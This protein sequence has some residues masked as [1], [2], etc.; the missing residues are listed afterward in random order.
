MI[1]LPIVKSESLHSD[2]PVKSPIKILS[3]VDT[4]VEIESAA[5]TAL[6]TKSA[7]ESLVSTDSKVVQSE[8]SKV[9]LATPLGVSMKERSKKGD[10]VP[11][12]IP[13][14]PSAA[15]PCEPA[16]VTI[17]KARHRRSSSV[18]NMTPRGPF[19]LMG[20][21]SPFGDS[22]SSPSGQSSSAKSKRMSRGYKEV[23]SRMDLPKPSWKAIVE[24]EMKGSKLKELLVA[25][26]PDEG[27]PNLAEYIQRKMENQN[28]DPESG[29]KE[30]D[31]NSMCS[32]DRC[33]LEHLKLSACL[34]LFLLCLAKDE[35]L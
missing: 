16:S 14:T 24:R 29:S 12:P 15:T 3:A 19:D 27:S 17:L 26:L 7:A 2:F 22:P 30:N 33:E 8:G 23:T 13:A 20:E 32:P 6:E 28:R 25:R 35:I 34:F 11:L 4:P 31:A 5:K 21:R 1:Y 10:A 18:G 9:P